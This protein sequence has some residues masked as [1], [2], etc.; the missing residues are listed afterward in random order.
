MAELTYTTFRDG[1]IRIEMLDGDAAS[2]FD[3]LTYGDG[4]SINIKGTG[5]GIFD[6]KMRDLVIQND[7]T[8]M[9][10]D[11]NHRARLVNENVGDREALQGLKD[12]FVSVVI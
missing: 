6:D 7:I 8:K 10:S 2:P 4:G 5:G 3:N 1:T 12:S 11:H 9:Q